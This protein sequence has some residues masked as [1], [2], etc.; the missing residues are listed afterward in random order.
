[1]SS[2]NCKVCSNK[3]LNPSCYF[4]GRHNYKGVEGVDYIIDPRG[5]PKY[6][7]KPS[8]NTDMDRAERKIR[9]EA[10]A[11]DAETW[12]KLKRFRMSGTGLVVFDQALLKAFGDWN[13]PQIPEINVKNYIQTID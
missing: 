8:I 10:A 7:L 4:C 2:I 13:D 3:G 11:Y 1:M 9:R 6:F 5:N 12:N